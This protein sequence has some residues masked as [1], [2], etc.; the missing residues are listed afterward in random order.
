MPTIDYL[1]NALSQAVLARKNIENCVKG[2]LQ[3]IDVKDALLNLN[4]KMDGKCKV[5]TADGEI[6]IV[7]EF[8]EQV[9]KNIEIF[10]NGEA[11]TLFG[12]R[13]KSRG[14]VKIPTAFFYLDP[15]SQQYKLYGNHS[16][17]SAR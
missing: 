8:D 12:R 11:P 14:L 17:S 6:Y 9:E 3:A 5:K 4:I 7:A 15:S 16:I 1:N 10:S 13:F 2:F